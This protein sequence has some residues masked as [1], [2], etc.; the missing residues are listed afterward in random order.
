MIWHHPVNLVKSRDLVVILWVALYFTDQLF[1]AFYRF[2][3]KISN[4]YDIDVKFALFIFKVHM[5]NPAKFRKVSMP[6][7]YI[8]ISGFWSLIYRQRQICQHF[9]WYLTSLW[10]PTSGENFMA[11]SL[12]VSEISGGW[13]PQDVIK[14]SEKVNTTNRS[15]NFRNFIASRGLS[16]DQ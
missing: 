7:R 10:I 15:N 14:W 8:F 4:L 12:A 9:F 5:D 3:C 6:K 16:H 11:I 2:F 13:P 1:S